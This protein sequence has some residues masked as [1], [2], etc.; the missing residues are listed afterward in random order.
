MTEVMRLQKFLSRAGVASRREAETLITQGRVRVNGIRVSELGTRV[1][2]DEDRVEVDGKPVGTRAH[3]WI[4]LHKPRGVVTTA[5]DPGGRPT[6]YSLLPEDAADLRYVGRLD[7]NTEGLLL[8]TNAG[9]DLHALTH[10][11]SRILRRYVARVVGIPSEAVFRALE[12]GVE[13]EDGVAKFEGVGT[14]QVLGPESAVIR[15]GLR[16]GRKRE[17]RRALEAVG[18]PVRG[19]RRVAFGPLELGNL[20]EGMWRELTREEIQSLRNA[21]HPSRP[22][23]PTNPAKPAIPSKPAGSPAPRKHGQHGVRRTTPTG[24]GKRS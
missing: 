15:L 24:K 23:K 21:T 13:L 19:L 18:H 12:A 7:R 10:P 6:V 4:L 9:D 3:R 14:E 20:P 5:D 16:E 17:V 1:T 2:P 22:A 8:F 11:S